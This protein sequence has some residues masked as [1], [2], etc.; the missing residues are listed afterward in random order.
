[1]Q[2]NPSEQNIRPVLFSCARNVALGICA[3][4]SFAVLA[5]TAPTLADGIAFVWYGWARIL[6]SNYTTVFPATLLEWGALIVAVWAICVA[7]KLER[8]QA[9]G[10]PF[11]GFLAALLLVFA[12]L[13]ANCAI[14]AV[15]SDWTIPLS[16][17]HTAME[18]AAG[19]T[20][21]LVLMACVVSPLW[22][23]VA[24]MIAH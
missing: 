1:M 11:F 18:S 16:V 13:P 22:A 9:N 24:C 3:L 6:T 5:I 8:A 10:S 20:V 14:V 15:M 2:S 17:G 19:V 12:V 7:V 23:L 21:F 4:V